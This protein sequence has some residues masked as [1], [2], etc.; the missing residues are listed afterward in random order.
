M[1]CTCLLHRQLYLICNYNQL[2]VQIQG[3]CFSYS[4]RYTLYDPFSWVVAFWCLFLPGL[5]DWV[6]TFSFFFLV[7]LNR[8]LNKLSQAKVDLTQI[9][10]KSTT[11]LFVSKNL[12]KPFPCLEMF[13][14][15]KAAYTHKDRYLSLCFILKLIAFSTLCGVISVCIPRNS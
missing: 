11:L 1:L 12:G 3:F 10:H 14:E 5:L 4:I 2:E 6:T 9:I 15:W 13:Y 8:K 7:S